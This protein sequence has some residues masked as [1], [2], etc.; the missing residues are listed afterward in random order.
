MPARVASQFRE[1]DPQKEIRKSYTA[2][3]RMA[4]E[5]TKT[6]LTKHPT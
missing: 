5:S 4:H 1:Q 3:A 2:L 6:P